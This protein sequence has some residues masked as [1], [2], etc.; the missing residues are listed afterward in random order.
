MG[1]GGGATWWPL[2]NRL[3]LKKAINDG[4]H[5]RI[6]GFLANSKM[7]KTTVFQG[8]VIWP[9]SNR[10]MKK[11]DSYDAIYADGWRVD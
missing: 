11:Y 4:T 5:S 7:H 1:S 3:P 6:L 9:L 10:E 2:K 8:L